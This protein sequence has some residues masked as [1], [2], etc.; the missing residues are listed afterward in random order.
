MAKLAPML[1][2]NLFSIC[3]PYPSLHL[4]PFSLS[5]CKVNMF[6]FCMFLVVKNVLYTFEANLL[7]AKG[8]FHWL[9]VLHLQRLL[10]F[11][12]FVAPL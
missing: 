6:Q 11:A 9:L 3:E 4:N 8:N 5:S 2:F 7:N 10:S 12:L 1:R